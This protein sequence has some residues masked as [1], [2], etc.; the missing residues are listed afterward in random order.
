MVYYFIN[1]KIRQTWVLELSSNFVAFDYCQPH[2][3]K[4]NNLQ[5]LVELQIFRVENS[6]KTHT[7][8]NSNAVQGALAQYIPVAPFTTLYSVTLTFESTDE[9][10]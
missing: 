7:C 4:R 5:S 1:L 3:P 8:D 10:L 2:L 9:N 6:G